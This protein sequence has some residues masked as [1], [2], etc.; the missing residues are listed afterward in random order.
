MPLLFLPAVQTTEMDARELIDP[1]VHFEGRMRWKD[2]LKKIFK[3][4]INLIFVRLH[5]SLKAH[6]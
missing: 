3:K 2:G 5:Y 6:R 1:I 4:I